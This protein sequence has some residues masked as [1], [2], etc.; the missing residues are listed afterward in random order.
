MPPPN[1]QVPAASVRA[2]LER[3][4]ELL[5]HPLDLATEIHG[6]DGCAGLAYITGLSDAADL[7][8]HL[9]LPLLQLLS[10]APRTPEDLARLLP[11]T[12][13]RPCQ[14]MDDILESLLQ[15]RA[16]LFLEGH[17]AALSFATQGW[18]RRPP[19]EPESERVIRG[20]REGFTET[21]DEN[22][23]MIR[24]WIKDSR[25]RAD[26]LEIGRRTRT[27]VAVVY[28]SDVA[29]PS[30]VGEVKKRLS[31]IDLDGVIESGYLEQLI[32]DRRASIFP[33]TQA[34]ERTDKAAAA[35]L[36]GRVAILADKSPFA[37]LVPVTVN[38]LYQSAEDYYFDFWLGG[39][40][41]L[42]RLLG[43]N[44]AVALPGLYVALAAV[45]PGLLP[46][47][48]ALALAAARLRIPIPL[49]AEVLLLELAVEFFRE[50][51]LR[52]PG[53]IGQTLGIV[54]GVVVGITSV[55]AG[56]VSPATLV[57]VAVTAI[58]SFTG[59]N[60]AMGI[61]WRLLKYILL[62]AAAAFGLYGMT[63]AGMLILAHAADVKSFGVSFLAPWAP[64][65]WTELA[66]APIRAPFW[67]KWRRPATYRPQ[68]RL[69]TGGAKREDEDHG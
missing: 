60:Y 29:Q 34:T 20:P 6:P 46:T 10:A 15:G 1:G 13:P 45:H 62:F 52:L 51:G 63:I 8:S 33:L 43:N 42:V 66:D 53:M 16:V 12:S 7:K 35:V 23:A 31:A 40:L 39:F 27:G 67:L 26:L 30:L 44:L 24:R 2:N 11:E 3:V 41:R 19:K 61:A 57:V 32:K 59:P 14:A 56:I 65:Q 68:D 25:L 47:Q 22:V 17:A 37:I 18:T 49:V 28:L 64:L 9:L 50:A 21:L 48:F 58:A 69:R 54:A 55:Q 4:D 36:E 5:G 38:E